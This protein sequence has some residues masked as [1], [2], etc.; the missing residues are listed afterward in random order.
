[1]NYEHDVYKGDNTQN[2]FSIPTALNCGGSTRNLTVDY[3]PVEHE[4]HVD[5][6]LS[7]CLSNKKSLHGKNCYSYFTEQVVLHT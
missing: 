1:M 4:L 3:C 7:V 5:T 2:M 6:A